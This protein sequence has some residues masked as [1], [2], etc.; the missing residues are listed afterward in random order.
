LKLSFHG[1]DRGVTGSCHMVECGG[2]RILIDCGLY[3]GGRELAEENAEA[4]GFEP[5]SIDYVLL[6]HAHLDHCGRLPLLAKRGFRG[7]IVTTG[8]SR[9]LARLVMLD[10][11]HLQEEEARYRARKAARHN[12]H[13]HR[14]HAATTPL[15]GVLDALNCLD[16][17]GRTASYAKPL[18]VCPGVRATFLDA[19]HI[20]GSA[21][22]LLELEEG[23]RRRRVVFSGDLGNAGRPLLGNPAPPRRD[24]PGRRL[25][26]NGK[27]HRHGATMQ[28]APEKACHEVPPVVRRPTV[29]V[30]W[31]QLHKDQPPDRQRCPDR[32]AE[33]HGAFRSGDGRRT[34]GAPPEPDHRAGTRAERRTPLSRPRRRVPGRRSS[35]TG[36]GNPGPTEGGAGRRPA[37]LPGDA[38]RGARLKR[39]CASQ[40]PPPAMATRF[41]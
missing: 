23:D 30:G 7:E 39:G 21:S 19:G 13:D 1:A 25:A 16:C 34:A 17:F 29:P 33:I 27:K 18:D 28:T 11:V 15:Y 3:Q 26:Y 36:T 37:R 10:S 24:C 35:P 22:I 6:T 20:L 32:L 2:K 31:R 38:A 41:P 40:P 9:E 5:E 12:H 14:E 4:F 8:A